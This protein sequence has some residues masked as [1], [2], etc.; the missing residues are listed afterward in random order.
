MRRT[1]Y[2]LR[3][4]KDQRASHSLLLRFLD[5]DSDMLLLRQCRVSLTIFCRACV[6]VEKNEHKSYNFTE[7]KHSAHAAVQYA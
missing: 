2:L 5:K 3:P 6:H 1:M 7:H 4:H